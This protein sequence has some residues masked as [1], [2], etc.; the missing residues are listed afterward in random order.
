MIF[1]R[2]AFTVFLQAPVITAIFHP[3][4]TMSSSKQAQSGLRTLTRDFST[5]SHSSQRSD[6]DLIY[7]PPTPAQPPKKQLTGVEQRLKDIQDAL[8]GRSE[9]TDKGP[10]NSSNQFLNKR[11]AAMIASEPP[12]KRRQL[13]DAWNDPARKP[14]PKTSMTAAT[15]WVSS[16]S[17]RTIKTKPEAAQV[18]ITVAGKSSKVAPVFLS[19]EQTQI[20]KLVENGNNVF[21]TGSAGRCS[22][23][24]VH[25]LGPS[26]TALWYRYR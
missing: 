8:A 11:P 5:D 9:P 14:P 10:T 12:A 15:E 18:P 21:Y 19:Q 6:P 23:V 25:M 16:S 1:S 2:D 3:T 7:W 17:S 24:S 13:P 22:R 26:L 20:L 4:S